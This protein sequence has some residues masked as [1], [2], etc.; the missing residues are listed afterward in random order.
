[1]KSAVLDQII[2][3]NLTGI[4]KTMDKIIE[5]GDIEKLYLPP[6]NYQHRDENTSSLFFKIS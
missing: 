5:A 3:E 2:F 1:M 6:N 4:E